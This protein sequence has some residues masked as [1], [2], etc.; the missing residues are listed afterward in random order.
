MGRK[1]D[2]DSSPLLEA[3]VKFYE[4]RQTLERGAECGY[5]ADCLKGFYKL[6]TTALP[7]GGGAV[8][9]MMQEGCLVEVA[10]RWCKW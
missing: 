7:S 5:S 10:V 1:P 8:V 4:M 9:E 6:L 2:L 3:P